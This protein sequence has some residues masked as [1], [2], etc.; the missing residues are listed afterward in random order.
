MQHV[1]RGQKGH[2]GVNIYEKS[3][4]NTLGSHPGSE[5]G[6]GSDFGGPGSGRNS[7]AGALSPSGDPYGKGALGESRTGL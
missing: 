6:Y 2:D 5:A 3:W 7:R 4:T 1:D